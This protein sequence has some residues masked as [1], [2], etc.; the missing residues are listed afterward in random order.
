MARNYFEKADQDDNRSLDKNEIK[1]ILKKMQISI[2]NKTLEAR[3]NAFDHDKNGTFDMKEFEKFVQ[4][5]LRKPEL[6]GLFKQYAKAYNGVDDQPVMT[7]AELA[8]FYKQEQKIDLAEQEAENIISRLKNNSVTPLHRDYKQVQKVS[9]YD[10]GT[11]IFSD[12]NLAFKSEHHGVYQVIFLLDK[13]VFSRN[14]IR[15]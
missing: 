2:D 3:F 10:F 14:I 15:I 9:F 1:K 12:L 7:A 5:L 4:Y 13:S 11:L 6:L 8:K